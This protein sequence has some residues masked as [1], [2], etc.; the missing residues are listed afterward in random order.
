MNCFAACKTNPAGAAGDD[1]NLVREAA[2]SVSPT[3]CQALP[4]NQLRIGRKVLPGSGS[5]IERNH[6]LHDKGHRV[7]HGE[8]AGIQP[9][10]LCMGKILEIG[11]AAFRREED[12]ALTPEDNGLRLMRPQERLP[13]GI[14]LNVGPVVVEVIK[15]DALGVWTS[16]DEGL[17]TVLG[18]IASS[19]SRPLILLHPS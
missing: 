4:L 13:F 16:S 15:L 14:K 9:M 10:N 17:M 2:H 11:L 18:Q 6:L 1:D 8:V 3:I 12:V 5:L 7:L 19:S